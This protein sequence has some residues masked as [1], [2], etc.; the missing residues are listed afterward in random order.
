MFLVSIS[1]FAKNYSEL[2]HYEQDYANQNNSRM[3]L[4]KYNEL[5]YTSN[6]TMKDNAKF[7][8]RIVRLQTLMKD[9]NYTYP[10]DFELGMAEEIYVEYTLKALIQYAQN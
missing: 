9:I 7:Q 8:T 4:P 10:T 6:G 2:V 3:E 1:D 5:I